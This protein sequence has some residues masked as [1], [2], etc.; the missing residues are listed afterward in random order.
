M[1]LHLAGGVGEHGRNCFAVHG[2]DVHFLVDCGIMG[3]QHPDLSKDEISLL[4]AVFLTHSHKDHSGS[5]S[6]LRENGYTGPLIATRA[7]LEQINPD[8]NAIALE[9]ICPE[10]TGMFHDLNIHWGRSGHCR[11]AV[12]FLFEAEGK[13][14][15]FSGDY[16]EQSLVYQCDPIRNV[17][18][19]IGVIDC[20]YGRHGHDRVKAG[21]RLAELVRKWYEKGETA[22]F[23][24]PKY[25]RGMD[26]IDLFEK[27]GVPV[28]ADKIQRHEIRKGDSFWCR[29]IPPYIP[30]KIRAFTDHGI[31]FVSDPQM[32]KEKTQ[33]LAG[34]VDHIV[35]TGTAEPGGM[36]YERWKKKEASLIFWPVHQG[37]AEYEAFCGA[38]QIRIAVPYHSKDMKVPDPMIEF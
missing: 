15:L 37:R 17:T 31:L 6:W 4:D 8:E 11:G 14:I 25:G 19:D 32:K 21:K 28:Y 23:P 12:S 29:E 16:S 33:R 38:N 35:L 26:L 13:R 30:E 22:L 36:A 9:D 10:K 1:L 34:C 5:L 7:C 24:V 2:S 3:H 27:A 20:A 18:A